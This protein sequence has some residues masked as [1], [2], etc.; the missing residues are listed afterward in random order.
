MGFPGQPGRSLHPVPRIGH[1]TA[2]QL[3]QDLGLAGVDAVTQ[4][5]QR[6]RLGL[7]G[8]D[9]THGYEHVFEST[10]RW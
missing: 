3:C 4:R 1:L 8:G 5:L 6:Q 2:V 9:I 7:Q 10:D